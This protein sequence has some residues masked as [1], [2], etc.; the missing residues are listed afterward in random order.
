[1]L[2]RAKRIGL[3]AVISLAAIP[4]IQTE[5]R[6]L[7]IYAGQERQ[8]C[9]SCHVDPSGGGL[10]TAFG[11]DYLRNR[12]RLV[13]QDSFPG[14]PTEQPEIVDNLPVGGDLKMLYD[15]LGR[16]HT[17]G[18][19]P[20]TVS[21]FY[22]MQGSFYISYAPIEQVRLY[23]N[24]DVNGTRDLWGKIGLPHDTYLRIGSFRPPYGLRTDDHTITEREDLQVPYNVY[25]YDT[26]IPD[27][28]VEV[29]IVKREY[30][31]Q[32]ALQN[33]GSGSNFDGDLNKAFSARFVRFYG[34]FMN[35]LSI[36]LNSAGQDPATEQLRYGTFGTLSVTPELLLL[37]AVD[38]G[39][40]DRQDD[41]TRI[42]LGWGEAC[43]FTP[44][45]LRL[46]GRYEYL[47]RDRS[48]E[49]ADSERYTIGADWVPYPFTTLT[50][51]YRFTSNESEPDL[52]E[53]VAVASFAF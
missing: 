43:Y 38:L 9:A 44:W 41:L 40:D 31:A 3:A 29:G 51:Y 28:G 53:I 22:R 8:L 42:F 14:L 17:D 45:D 27:A 34:P 2:G 7:P 36:R 21:S 4:C 19:F 47:D 25:G 5:T 37:G 49:F 16:R 50:G 20:N 1:M 30:Y 23:Y 24:Q 15:A 18:S 52:E 46:R 10:R 26:R 39:E 33:G 35:G 13:P 48:A 6:A 12:H 11:F 32:A